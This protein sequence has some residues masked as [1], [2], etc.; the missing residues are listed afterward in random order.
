MGTKTTYPPFRSPKNK[1]R[2]PATRRMCASYYKKKIQTDTESKKCE[3]HAVGTQILEQKCPSYNDET[4]TIHTD[5]PPY[6]LDV[7]RSDDD[8]SLGE[9]GK[10]PRQE[11]L[12]TVLEDRVKEGTLPMPVLLRLP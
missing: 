9:R 3:G 12:R 6:K 5:A 7:L 8:Q 4:L 1:K 2:K 11:Y 10:T